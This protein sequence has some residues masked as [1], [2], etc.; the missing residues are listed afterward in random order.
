MISTDAFYITFPPEIT[1][2]PSPSCSVSTLLSNVV[3]TSPSSNQ[4]KAVLTFT[5]TPSPAGSMFEF[6]VVAK[7]APSTQITSIFSAISLS[8]SGGNKIAIYTGV[9]VGGII[10]S[11][12]AAATGTLT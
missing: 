2:P 10:N 6:N 7:N 1:L 12:P 9:D 3:C 8:D 11:A 5:T 4:L